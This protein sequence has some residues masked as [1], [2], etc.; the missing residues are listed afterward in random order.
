MAGVETVCALLIAEIS[1]SDHVQTVTTIAA[2]VLAMLYN[3]HVMHHAQ[4]Q[5]DAVVGPDRLPTFADCDALPYVQA[6]VR[7]TLRWRPPAPLCKFLNNAK[8][9]RLSLFVST[10]KTV[11]AR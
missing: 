1:L 3:P 9:C 2:F 6:I 5:I 11:H 4:E 10:R 8:L 7:E